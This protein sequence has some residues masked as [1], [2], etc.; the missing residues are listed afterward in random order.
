MRI[1]DISLRKMWEHLLQVSKDWS[2]LMDIER[3]EIEE[4]MD[5]GYEIQH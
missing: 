1:S 4:L 2:L 5:L 3:R